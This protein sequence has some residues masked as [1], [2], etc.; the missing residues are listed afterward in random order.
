VRAAIG[1][2][3]HHRSD[4][5]DFGPFNAFSLVTMIYLQRDYPILKISM[6]SR[7]VIMFS[8]SF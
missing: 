2:K 7:K 8:V 1:E 3:L 6:T 5:E 4:S